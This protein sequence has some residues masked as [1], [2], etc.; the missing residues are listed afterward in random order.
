VSC[1]SRT[2]AG[3]QQ[4]GGWKG[5]SPASEEQAGLRLPKDAPLVLHKLI[6]TL[7]RSH[8]PQLCTRARPTHCHLLDWNELD[9]PRHDC[10][11][12]RLPTI[13]LLD[14]Q[15]AQGWAWS[16]RGFKERSRE[17]ALAQP[18]RRVRRWPL[19]L[20]CFHKQLTTSSLRRCL[21]STLLACLP[22]SSSAAHTPLPTLQASPYEPVL[23]ATP[24]SQPST[25]LS[26]SG[27]FSQLMILPTRKSMSCRASSWA[28]WEG[29][30]SPGSREGS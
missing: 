8:A 23:R 27:C 13:Y 28:W 29:P 7:P 30:A 15:A 4:E 17:G 11:R 10:P 2:T 22:T 18:Q 9:Q 6:P 3:W 14:V 26:A 20:C 24:P 1:S 25:H 12:L 5:T 16:W 19:L 21:P